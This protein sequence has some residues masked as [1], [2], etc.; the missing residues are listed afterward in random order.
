[1]RRDCGHEIEA[2]GAFEFFGITPA[3]PDCAETLSLYNDV[4]HAIAGNVYAM[5]RL[6]EAGYIPGINPTLED[7]NQAGVVL[8][9]QLT[10][11]QARGIQ[12]ED[13]KWRS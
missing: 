13:N 6:A 10:P 12:E 1:M 5:A 11:T 3:C 9:A 7:I 8:Y 4:R 2:G